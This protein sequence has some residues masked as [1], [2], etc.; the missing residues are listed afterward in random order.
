MAVGSEFD[1]TDSIT[2]W[3]QAHGRN[4]AWDKFSTSSSWFQ[5][6]IFGN[7]GQQVLPTS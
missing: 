1:L 4:N 2:A 7:A 6:S 3:S 5:R